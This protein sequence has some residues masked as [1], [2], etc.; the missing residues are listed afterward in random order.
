MEAKTVRRSWAALSEET[1]QHVHRPKP[2]DLCLPGSG[3]PSPSGSPPESETEEEELDDDSEAGP[4]SR[5][6]LRKRTS[7]T[8]YPTTPLFLDSEA[9]SKPKAQG[10]EPRIGIDIG[11][12]LTR[13]GDPN[14]RGSLDEWDST[15]EA[16]GALDAVRKIT[17]TF[18][19]SNTF[20][21]SKVRPGGAMH[22]RMEQWLH[23]EIMF[24]QET[25]LPKENIIFVRA[26][27]GPEGKGV[28]CEKLGI[29]HFVDDKLEVLKSVFEDEAGNS[30]FVVERFQ[31]LLFHFAKGGFGQVPPEVDKS[32]LSPMMRRFYRPVANWA[33]VLEQLR[34]KL[35]GSLVKRG[36]ELLVPA[37][38]R[39]AKPRPAVPKV[40]PGDRSPGPWERRDE[41]SNA[42]FWQ[43]AVSSS[44]QPALQWSNSAVRPK[45]VLKPR[46]TALG[47]V[48][49]VVPSQPVAAVRQA[50]APVAQQRAAS[51]VAA[52]AA[53]AV[54]A[55]PATTVV[56]PRYDANGRQKLQLKPRNPMLGPPG[57]TAE[58]VAAAAEVP[59]A[60]PQ[61]VQVAAAPPAPAAPACPA[62]QP[63]PAGGRP[64]LVLKPRTA[65][66]AQQQQVATA[67]VAVVSHA[68]AAA[69]APPPV[70]MQ[71]PS[72]SVRVTSPTH[73]VVPT[74]SASVNRAVIMQAPSL[75]AAAPA[76]AQPPTTSAPA[77][78]KDPATGRPKL[79]LKPRTLPLPNQ[80]AEEAA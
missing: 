40:R 52:A 72:A 16:D 25:G 24:C 64:R 20:L 42:A 71:S 27:D 4:T 53:V 10:T 8:D 50:A 13:E 31:G 69:A 63:D 35:P 21:V 2:P 30:R 22:R 6:K 74:A 51:P 58:P 73:R 55:A 70:A 76:A 26:V 80:D 62:M 77:V 46:S 49:S 9:A 36:R 66:V 41:A 28:A 60:A 75:A 47:P 17:E 57:E 34:E 65:P 59:E 18:G 44:A 32:E 37:S 54:V 61:P 14:Y 1:P 7:W 68:A 38:P 29:S 19:P 67:P 5:P 48:G 45:L 15:W 12:V 43:P 39:S 78:Q 33:Q 11:G 56:Q 79:M 3:S 23:E